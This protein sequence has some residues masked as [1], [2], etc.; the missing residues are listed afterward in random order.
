MSENYALLKS[1]GFNPR[2]CQALQIFC[3]ARG[4]SAK[5]MLRQAARIYH[6]SYQP[7]PPALSIPGG[8]MGDDDMVPPEAR[9]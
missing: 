2:E 8:C 4:L 3:T 6:D 5:A 7:K 9:L 1:L